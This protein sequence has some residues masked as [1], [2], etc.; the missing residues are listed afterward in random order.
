MPVPG[1]CSPAGGAGPQP[2]KRSWHSSRAAQ[3][4]TLVPPLACSLLSPLRS[5][6]T[7][8]RCRCARLP[9][10]CCELGWTSSRQGPPPARLPAARCRPW[11]AALHKCAALAGA[12]AVAP[13]PCMASGRAAP[14]RPAGL[15]W[16]A[17]RLSATPPSPMVA[18]CVSPSARPWAPV[19]PSLLSAG[20]QH[21][22]APSLPRQV[23]RVALGDAL[24][25]FLTGPNN[26]TLGEIPQAG[27]A[28]R[29]SVFYV[30]A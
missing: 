4:Q 16:L 15:V 30:D 1:P 20:H 26:W 8:P 14:R 18:S 19:E 17:H 5:T 23:H 21:P 27:P 11:R 2:V 22:S 24:H 6:M 25:Y 9:S 7:S 13:A 29:K 12:L 28:Q 3:P 10:T